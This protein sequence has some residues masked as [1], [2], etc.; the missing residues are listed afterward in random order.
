MIS[1]IMI[2]T[3]RRMEAGESRQD[4]IIPVPAPTKNSMI[5]F[6]FF[7]FP[8]LKLFVVSH[9]ITPQIALVLIA[10]LFE[11]LIFDFQYS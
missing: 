7:I 11:L 1:P 3:V 4:T 2:A 9:E 8:S 6:S 5:D 10:V